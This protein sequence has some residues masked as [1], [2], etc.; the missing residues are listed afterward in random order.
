MV[1]WESV[2]EDDRASPAWAQVEVREVKLHGGPHP[3]GKEKA[4]A[5][6]CPL[7][8]EP[9]PAS[10]F[11]TV[12]LGTLGAAVVVGVLSALQSRG[13]FVTT[14]MGFSLLLFPILPLAV[15]AALLQ[16]ARREGWVRYRQGVVWGMVVFTLAPIVLFALFIYL[17]MKAL[18]NSF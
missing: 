12:G 2:E 17:L 10:G 6:P 18:G 4:F 9:G 16:R 13:E 8:D 1:Q 15:G 11:F 3:R 5:L 14:L 7:V